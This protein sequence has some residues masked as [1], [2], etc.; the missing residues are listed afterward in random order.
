M[1]IPDGK[2]FGEVIN[3]WDEET[4]LFSITTIKGNHMI[5]QEYHTFSGILDIVT[6]HYNIRGKHESGNHALMGIPVTIKNAA[7]NISKYARQVYRETLKRLKI[8]NNFS[9]DRKHEI[10]RDLFDVIEIKR[11][12]EDNRA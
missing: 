3:F 2:Y 11:E 1:K 9:E 8:F 5:T 12:E 6:S 7:K 10:I 4:P